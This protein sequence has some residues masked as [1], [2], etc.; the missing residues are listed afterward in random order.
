L[1]YGNVNNVI[2]NRWT[3]LVYTY[4]P[5]TGI[6]RAY[7]DGAQV[8]QETLGAALA[9]A[10][11]GSAGPAPFRVG[12]QNNATGLV[13][14]T[15]RAN[16]L[17]IGEIRVFNRVL[18]SASI[19]NN[20][21]NGRQAYGLN[22][23]DGDGMP[24]WHERRYPGFL[25]ETNPAD[26]AADQDGDTLSNAGE[27]LNSIGGVQNSTDPTNP[28]TDGDGIQ[29]G[30]EVANVT[31]PNNR[32]TDRDGVEDAREVALGTSPNI[33]DSDGDGALDVTEVLYGSDPL[34]A[35]SLPDTSVAQPLVNLDLTA[36]PEG[37]ISLWTNNN[38]L[39]WNFA[40]STNNLAVSTLVIS[41]GI[42]FNGTAGRYFT[43]PGM[44]AHMGVDSART[45]E[46]WIFN[47]TIGNE[48]T[49]FAY[50]ARGADD[51]NSAFAHGL[52]GQ[53]GAHQ[54]WGGGGDVPWGTNAAAITANTTPNAWT[55]VAYTYN[56]T[57]R[58]KGAYRN[59]ML[60]NSESNAVPL[61]TFLNDP[62]DPLNALA[63]PIGR[64]LNFRVAA[65]NDNSGVVS[66]AALP[67]MTIARVR[68]YD[69]A[70][71][72][73][74]I[75][76]HYN[77]EVASFPNR[78]VITGVQ[79]NPANGFIRFNWSLSPGRTYAVETNASLSNPAGWS[80]AVTG[81]TSGVYSN[82]AAGA[83]NNYRVR[84]ETP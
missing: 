77:A 25:D 17:S 46:A 29:D 26:G 51:R 44:P 3:Y 14:G 84:I 31:N 34:S 70:L 43:G 5:L 7:V 50:G 8:N 6:Q 61:N 41:K 69:V 82:N 64:T 18:D 65:Q 27:F 9:I 19:S 15:G 48:E 62:S 66:G 35:A 24:D 63:Q 76:A 79:I 81:E 40:A 54:F 58:F 72:A 32:D 16:G 73:A 36:I 23:T 2:A 78:P 11:V 1:G 75:A 21:V 74:D 56:P 57:N 37:N 39:G 4:D 10:A 30:V 20:F 28:D 49:V 52:N 42:T 68:A 83:Q 33:A 60:M 53:F 45:V 22:D 55:F 59:G 38:V 12:A 47:P 71:E 80:A 67:S 13:D